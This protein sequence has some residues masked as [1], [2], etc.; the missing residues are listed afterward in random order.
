MKPIDFYGSN[1]EL[2]PSG[3]EYSDN[4]V[5]VHSLRVWTDGEQCV[6]CWKM[7]VIE[8]I[9]AVIFG[10]V[11]ISTLSGDTQYPMYSEVAS[12]YFKKV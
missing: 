1:R 9:K 12:D 8:R 3:K 10:K 7:S 2:T 5:A 11:W 4:V 6:S